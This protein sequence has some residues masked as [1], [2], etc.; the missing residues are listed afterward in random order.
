MFTK[1]KKK[2]TSIVLWGDH[3]Y[4]IR[5]NGFLIRL[6]FRSLHR[7]TF[8][9]H[10]RISPYLRVRSNVFVYPARFAVELTTPGAPKE[11]RETSE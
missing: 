10:Y 11:I 3:F 1:K 2:H 7:T 8:Y 4:R 6:L 9:R 5:Q